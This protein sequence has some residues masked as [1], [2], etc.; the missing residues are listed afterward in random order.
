VA[1][2]PELRKR[3]IRGLAIV[4]LVLLLIGISRSSSAVLFPPG[5][6]RMW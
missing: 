6:W 3:Q 1:T 5:W 4:G 2:D